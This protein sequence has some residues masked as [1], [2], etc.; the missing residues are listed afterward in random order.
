MLFKRMDS[1]HTVQFHGF[2]L[3]EGARVLTLP[4]LPDPQHDGE[5]SNSYY[6]YSW[7]LARKLEAHIIL[8]TTIL[9]HD[10]AWD[11]AIDEVCRKLREKDEKIHHFLYEK[12]GCGTHGHIR[13]SEAEDMAEQ[14]KM[15][16]KSQKIYE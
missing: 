8:T 3:N 1:C 4:P 16:I 7:I 9:N 11:T 15:F 5:L 12:N 6:S 2:Y 13:I 14:L 10:A